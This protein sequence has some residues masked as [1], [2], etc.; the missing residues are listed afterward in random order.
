M[1]VNRVQVGLDLLN[2]VQ[3]S[4]CNALTTGTG[5]NKTPGTKKTLPTSDS[6]VTLSWW[7]LYLDSCAIYHTAFMDLL[8]DNVREVNTVLKGN[9]N[10]GV[11]TSN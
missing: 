7:K 4:Y 9:C 2:P 8:L 5:N 3:K 6:R 10:A 11:T 1:G